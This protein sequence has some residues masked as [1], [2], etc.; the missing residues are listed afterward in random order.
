MGGQVL[1]RSVDVNP[2]KR[3]WL[4]SGRMLVLDQVA[5][6]QW[7]NGHRSPIAAANQTQRLVARD[8]KAPG[9]GGLRRTAGMTA[10]PGPSKRL[11]YRLLGVVRA[12][13]DPQRLGVAAISD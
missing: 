3:A 11:L 6:L 2:Q 13:Q 5:V 8:L 4:L 12:A 10:A 1:E 9:K 7:D